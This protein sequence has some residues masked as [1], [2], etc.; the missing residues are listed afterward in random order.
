MTE[1]L[2]K[3]SEQLFP[4]SS[5]RRPIS[6]GAEEWIGRKIEVFDHGF[7]Y[8]VD[9]MGNDE[10][11]EQAARVSYGKGT[12][13]VSEIRGLIR[14]LRRHDHTTPFEMGELK[15]H[16]KLP[17]FVARQKIR[18][19]T[20][21]INEYSARYSILDK[22][23]YIPEPEDIAVQSSTN[24]QGRG[25]VVTAE[26]AKYV[27]DLLIR[28]ATSSY[29]TYEELL[30]DDGQGNPVDPEKPMIA[31]ELARVG[32]TLNYYTQWYWKANLHNVFHFLKLRMDAHAQY[33]I[34]VY[35]DAIAQIVKDSFPLAWEAFEDYDLYASKLSRPEK[36]VLSQVLAD[37]GV[38]VTREELVNA[39]RSTG[40]TN[41]R[42][43]A[44]L[45]EKFGELG[46]TSS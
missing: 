37:H 38:L 3:P 25:E 19:R 27:R 15:F 16:E 34:R 14:Y 35:A 45:L 42:E 32:L 20:A 29:E 33:E 41:K 28:D 9:Y 26:Q 6:E 24:R 30:N 10:A 31:R 4:E 39:A 5:T 8:L 36:K 43:T 13:S 46:L 21:S 40:M 11:I 18:S 2:D 17:I 12:R 23:F 7:V 22:E 44:E 1:E